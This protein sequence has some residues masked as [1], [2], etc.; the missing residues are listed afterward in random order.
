MRSVAQLPTLTRR[1]QMGVSCSMWGG[2]TEVRCCLQTVWDNC[3]G[4]VARLASSVA[5]SDRSGVAGAISK[6]VTLLSANFAWR[7][8]SRTDDSLGIRTLRPAVRQQVNISTR[9]RSQFLQE[10]LWTTARCRTALLGTSF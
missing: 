10:N 6:E 4:L 9:V 5:P 2:G 1:P 8:L 3:A 7:T